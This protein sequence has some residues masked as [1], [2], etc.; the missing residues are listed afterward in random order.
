M[1]MPAAAAAAFGTWQWNTAAAA[2]SFLV[3]FSGTL[4]ILG[5]GGQTFKVECRACRFGLSR[6]KSTNPPLPYLFFHILLLLRLLGKVEPVLLLASASSGFIIRLHATFVWENVLFRVSMATNL[7]R[8]RCS[9]LFIGLLRHNH[10]ARGGWLQKGLLLQS[11]C[12]ADTARKRERERERGLC[13]K[14]CVTDLWETLQLLVCSF[15]RSHFALF[16]ERWVTAF[17]SFPRD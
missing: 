12:P 15:L 6:G 17:F 1:P 9:V 16:A 10:G 11:T 7:H 4:L 13:P 5:S 8:R 3:M 14:K 2:V